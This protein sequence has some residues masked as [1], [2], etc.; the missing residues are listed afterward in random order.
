MNFIETNSGRITR[1]A[2]EAIMKAVIEKTGR[3]KSEFEW[4]LYISE[5][6]KLMRRA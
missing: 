2:Y 6:E 5:I 4:R 3:P 1:D